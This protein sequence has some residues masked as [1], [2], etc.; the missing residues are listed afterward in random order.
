MTQSSLWPKIG[1][2]IVGV[3]RGR[4]R[5]AS[6]KAIATIHGVT[7]TRQ[8]AVV[9]INDRLEGTTV[10]MGQRRKGGSEDIS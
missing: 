3:R 4:N 2:W 10:D 8:L 1:E 5:K 7:W 9:R 6:R